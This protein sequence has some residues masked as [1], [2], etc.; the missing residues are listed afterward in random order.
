MEE[1]EREIVTAAERDHYQD[2]LAK[3]QTERHYTIEGTTEEV[4]NTDVQEEV[5]A[6]VQEM[7]E[8]LSS[9]QQRLRKNFR[10]SR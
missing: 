9:A 3:L 10:S 4:V 6:K 7:N 2:E 5:Q 8:R 1:S